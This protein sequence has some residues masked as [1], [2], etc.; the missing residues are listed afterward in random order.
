MPLYFRAFDNGAGLKSLPQNVNNY[1]F[2]LSDSKQ[3]AFL[4][5][6]LFLVT[7]SWCRFWDT[8]GS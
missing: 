1:P 4:E 2:Q 6:T 3:I 5:W 8:S 7:V